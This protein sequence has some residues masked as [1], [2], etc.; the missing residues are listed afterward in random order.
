[1]K[2]VIIYLTML[3]FLPLFLSAQHNEY[4]N[5][6]ITN[7]PREQ[8][9]AEPQNWSVVQ[10]NR[11]VL[12]VGNLG[13]VLEYDGA[14]WT[15]IPNANGSYV[16]SMS[17]DRNGRIYIGNVG[18]FGYLKP[19]FRGQ[20]NYVSLTPELDTTFQNV[21]NVYTHGDT[22][23]FSSFKYIFQY[24]GDSLIHTIPVGSSYH[25]LDF[26]VNGTLYVGD[27]KHGLMKL[28]DGRVIKVAGGHFYQEK[29]IF[30]IL[31]YDQDQLLVGTRTGLYIYQ[32]SNGRSCSVERLGKG[33]A[34][35]NEYIRSVQ[36]YGGMRLSDGNLAFYSL[37][38]G[39]VV[40]DCQTGN[41]RY[42]YSDYNGLQ[43]PTVITAFENQQ[44]H[45]CL[46]LNN[47]ISQIEYHSP[48]RHFGKETGLKGIPTDVISFSDRRYVATTM[49]VFLQQ[50]GEQGQ[51]LFRKIPQ[52]N[53]Q[54][55]DLMVFDIPGKDSKRLLAGTY[56]GI[57]DITDPQQAYK[58]DGEKNEDFYKTN[59]MIQSAYYPNR[60]YAVWTGGLVLFEYA[61][62][63]Q[64]KEIGRDRNIEA[65]LTYLQEEDS[66]TLWAGSDMSG[67]L[68]IHV[69][70]DISAS[71]EEKILK[72][73]NTHVYDTAHGLPS[74]DFNKVI[75]VGNGIY[76]LTR[77]GFYRYK[78]NNDR[79]VR[80]TLFDGRYLGKHVRFFSRNCNNTY[81][82]IYS[83]PGSSNEELEQIMVK[84]DSLIFSN[85]A[86]K[87]MGMTNFQGIYSQAGHTWIPTANGLY[88]YNHRYQRD[89][90]K[91]YPAL[92]RQVAID[93]DS[94]LFRGTF[95]ED[96][97]DYQVG[98]T[99]PGPLHYELP[100]KYN[101]ISFVFAAP[102]FEKEEALCYSYRLDGYD[103][104]WSSWS[105]KNSKE[106][107]NLDEGHYIFLVKARNIYGKE[108]RTAR[109]EFSVEPPW[110]RS[111]WAYLGYVVL[112]LGLIILIVKGYTRRLKKE[113]ER[114]EQIVQARTREV[115]AQ[116][117]EIEAQRDEIALKNLYITDSL[118]YARKI[119][120]AVLPQD[121]QKDQMM[122]EHFI[123]Y[124]PR[125]IVSGDFYWISRKNGQLFII[126]ADCTGH[127]V[128]GAFMSMLGISLL[129]EIVN[130][131]EVTQANQVLNDLRDEVKRTLRQ[132]G[133]EGEA[134]DGMD[135]A[136]AMVDQKKM[137]MQYA[138]AYNPLYLFREGE[139]I[140]YKADRMPIGIYLKEKST[141]TNHSIELRKGDTL[142]LSSD[143]YPDQFG[144][145]EG[146]KFKTQRL[147][148]LLSRSQ[149]ETME[150]Q[151]KILE[152]TIEEWRGDHEQI[153]DILLIGVRI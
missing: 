59:R 75:R 22:V 12:Y 121:E 140:E 63:G 133:K 126:A 143:G 50:A 153:D 152:Q 100:Y 77:D 9:D 96:T 136:L 103:D 39:L 54:V 72:G 111:Y 34:Q 116:K 36:L 27:Y 147:K 11:G 124:R 40:A 129:N 41:I 10:D 98:M 95:Y 148:R 137:K 8:Y 69:P 4:G 58:I 115:V 73:I 47:G 14:S 18:D 5:H 91:S 64:L 97:L 102:Y 78:A 90:G 125:D 49:G 52:I 32:T 16:R 81:W 119:Q 105:E 120:N 94:T 26:M 25:F 106:Y 104:D 142:Y 35:L 132:T 74:M 82:V 33:F 150:E 68:K 109:Y 17:V 37:D 60:L 67:I 55:R 66:T 1:M 48:I 151:K 118:E 99:Q 107:T 149:H 53:T 127:G 88:S 145:S 21:W 144:G 83:Q 65:N 38:D 110:Y 134:K 139:L 23:Y 114:L 31:P 61:G 108:S 84:G 19:D 24:L 20:L 51:P 13:S 15:R 123:L 141:F 76:H 62:N 87:R 130:R 128:P 42:H 2:K 70:P 85:M 89:Y 45:I 6:F 113:K 92:I 146:T 46:G 29:D 28:K 57:Y 3:L 7:Y 101:D 93:F 117:E 44:G 30:T 56:Q 138:G 71:R 131:H 135:M 86:F 112:A 122:P 43:D 80:D 79:F